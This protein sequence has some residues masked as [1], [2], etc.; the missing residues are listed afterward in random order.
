MR[1]LK[2]NAATTPRF[3][4]RPVR[5]LTLAAAAVLSL[6]ACTQYYAWRPAR[7]PRLAQRAEPPPPP[8]PAP[9]PVSLPPMGPVPGSAED[10]AVKAGDRVFFG[11]DSAA[12]GAQ[13]ERNLILSPAS[14]QAGTGLSGQPPR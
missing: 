13:E 2:T 3:A 1:H 7:Q 10:F 9:A 6:S 4:R 12:S 5:A 14:R 11:F 8:A